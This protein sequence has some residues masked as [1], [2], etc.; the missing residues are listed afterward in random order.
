MIKNYKIAAEEYVNNGGGNMVMVYTVW[1]PD[2]K[3]DRK[4]VV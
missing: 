1:L 3:R 2:E 4:S